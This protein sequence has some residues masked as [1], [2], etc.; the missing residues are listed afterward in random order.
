MSY[1][2]EYLRCPCWSLCYLAAAVQPRPGRAQVLVAIPPRPAEATAVRVGTWAPGARRPATAAAAKL[3]V[4]ELAA[5]VLAALTVAAVEEPPVPWEPA[6]RVPV[7][8][9]G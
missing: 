4:R 9:A 5:S 1:P 7:G 3:V 2:A 6:E 8:V